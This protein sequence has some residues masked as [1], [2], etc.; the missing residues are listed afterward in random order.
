M[1]LEELLE[2]AF[3]ENSS[4]RASER[5]P[6]GR[7][8]EIFQKGVKYLKE[9]AYL[10]AAAHFLA[11]T[12]WDPAHHKAWNNLGIAYLKLG[13]AEEARLAFEKALALRPDDPLV[14]KNLTLMTSLYQKSGKKEEKDGQ[15]KAC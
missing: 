6:Q 15:K 8:E 5:A 9:G 7:G 4:S 10:K 12:I 11:V 2:E 3:G 1:S 14:K 13:E